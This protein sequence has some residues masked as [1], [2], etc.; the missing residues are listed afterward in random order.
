M[1]G[2]L[3][4]Q[5]AL[6]IKEQ[7]RGRS[8]EAAGARASARL[9]LVGDAWVCLY[10]SDS[11]AAATPPLLDTGQPTWVSIA[12]FFE[13]ED[14]CNSGSSRSSSRCTRAVDAASLSTGRCY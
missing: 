10:R 13:E 12:Q 11:A 7:G 8:Q 1:G 4:L 9:Q 2:L 6:V 3:R 14:S 5:A